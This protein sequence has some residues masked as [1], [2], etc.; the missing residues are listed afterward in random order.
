ML[1]PAS[2]SSGKGRLRRPLPLFDQPKQS[3]SCTSVYPS[4]ASQ[5][6]HKKGRVWYGAITRVV[7]FPR[8]PGVHEYANFVGAA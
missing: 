7:L 4:L 1:F 8:N 3:K 5:P 6:L 2:L